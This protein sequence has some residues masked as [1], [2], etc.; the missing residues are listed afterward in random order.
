MIY[1][2][3]QRHILHLLVSTA[4]PPATRPRVE[5]FIYVCTKTE[6]YTRES[7]IQFRAFFFRTASVEIGGEFLE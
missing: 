7:A 1:C 3:I 5:S 4:P 2:T 6:L